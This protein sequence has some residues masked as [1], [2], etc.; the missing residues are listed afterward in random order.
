[1][2]FPNTPFEPSGVLGTVE[3]ATYIYT[4]YT[5]CK[6]NT[7]TLLSRKQTHAWSS[8]FKPL[9]STFSRAVKEIAWA[10]RSWAHMDNFLGMLPPEKEK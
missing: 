10:L 9:I 3:F 5:S 7:D 1:M 8:P 4:S 2:P 6:N